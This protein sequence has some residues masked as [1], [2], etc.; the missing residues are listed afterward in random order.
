MTGMDKR[1]D[2]SDDLLSEVL[3][4]CRDRGITETIF[5]YRSVNDWR[6]VERLREDRVTIRTAKRLREF[7][8]TERQKDDAP[9]PL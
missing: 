3:A 9:A 5:G 1:D 6:V 2:L 8:A 4:F 7:I